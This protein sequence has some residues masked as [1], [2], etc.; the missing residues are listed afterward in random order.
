MRNNADPAMAGYWGGYILGLVR[1]HYGAKPDDP[2]DEPSDKFT[3]LGYKDGIMDYVNS[4][5]I[6]RPS[7]GNRMMPALTVT[8]EL[9]K[10]IKI[11]A[12]KL[13]ISVTDFRRK[14][15]EHFINSRQKSKREDLKNE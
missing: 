13:D 2:G 9:E 14:A 6:G 15:Y 3:R 4:E 5:K 10:N 7:I 8:E 11:M 12:E 1:T